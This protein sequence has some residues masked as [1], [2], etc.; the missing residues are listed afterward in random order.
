MA[1]E[2]SMA[3]DESLR[4]AQLSG[5]VDVLRAGRYEYAS[6][7]ISECDGRQEPR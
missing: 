2:M 6:E 1:N 4:K 3:R 7:W 5:D